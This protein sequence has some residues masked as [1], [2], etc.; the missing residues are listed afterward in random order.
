MSNAS[1]S[2]P[3][4]RAASSS[5]TQRRGEAG[6]KRVH[7]VRF[8]THPPQSA[9]RSW[10]ET[11]PAAPRSRRRLGV[12]SRGRE[13]PPESS[14]PACNETCRFLPVPSGPGRSFTNICS[15]LQPNA[16]APGSASPMTC[17]ATRLRPRS[18]IPIGANCAG[19]APAAPARSPPGPPTACALCAASPIELAAPASR[20]DGRT[21]HPR[22][23][24][25]DA[26]Q[27]R[28]P[29][30]RQSEAKGS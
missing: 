21:S 20:A 11:T 15:S 18:P 14:A 28:A 27:R 29:R 4:Q 12:E 16:C 1:S 10:G 19:I 2:R 6:S 5:P 13:D 3:Q 7:I 8:S 17:S 24:L 9:R 23:T 25:I 30:L 26:S 22:R